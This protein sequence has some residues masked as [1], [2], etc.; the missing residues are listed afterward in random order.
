M[1]K[2]YFPPEEQDHKTLEMN[3]KLIALNVFHTEKQGKISHLY[4]SEFHKT[5][6]KQ[7]ILLMINDDRK[8]HFLAVKKLNGLF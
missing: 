6:E 5:R 3:N 7:A 2:Y 1:G 4:K 8:Q